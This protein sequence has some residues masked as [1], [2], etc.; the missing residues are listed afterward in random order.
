MRRRKLASSRL[1]APDVSRQR[2]FLFNELLRPFCIR[3]DRFDL[4]AMA[5]NAL[6]TEETFDI[7]FRESRDPVEIEMMESGAE[8]ITLGQDGAPAQP[9]LEA[10]QT[11]LLE[12]T[13]IVIDRKAPF[14]V[15]VVEKFRRG[16]TPAAT[17]FAIR[18][19]D[20]LRHRSA[21]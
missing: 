3:D 6:I 11:Q 20:R 14:G 17:R 7:T 1:E 5:N 9:G 10:F 12:E 19:V 2:T 16:M 18:A 4:A 21:R 15:V 8:V 13:M